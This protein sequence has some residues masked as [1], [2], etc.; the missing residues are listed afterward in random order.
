MEKF[1]PANN[2]EDRGAESVKL[3]NAFE[4][5]TPEQ[6]LR[7]LEQKEETS[8]FKKLADY[9]KELPGN[10]FRKNK[11]VKAAAA[12]SLMLKASTLFSGLA[13]A[14][15][16]KK[17]S[18][19]AGRGSAVA[20]NLDAINLEPPFD[21][22]QIV[23]EISLSYEAPHINRS[24]YQ[25][26][27]AEF[28][29]HFGLPFGMD[30]EEHKPAVFFKDMTWDEYDAAEKFYYKNFHSSESASEFFR[31]FQIDAGDYSSK[32]KMMILRFLGWKLAMNFDKDMLERGD[33]AFVSD[34]AMFEALKAG[35]PAGICGNQ[36]TFLAKAAK[37]LGVEAWL[38]SEDNH[39]VTGAIAENQG[40]KEIVFFNIIDNKNVSFIP[41]GTLNYKEA[42]GIMERSTK[43]IALFNTIVGNTE[44]QLFPVNSYA[45][46]NM[47]EA[48]GFKNKDEALSEKLVAGEIVRPRNIEI[49]FSPEKKKFEFNRDSI[50]LCFFDYR[51]SGNAYNSLEELNS[52]RGSLRLG[53]NHWGI[54]AETTFMHF[55][56]KDFYDNKFPRE[57]V[58]SRLAGD[59]ID[60][61]QL[62]KGEFGSLAASY[63]ATVEGGMNYLLHKDNFAQETFYQG[64]GGAGARVIYLTPGE[65]GKIFLE[66]KNFWHGQCNDF[67]RQDLV[68]KETS[69]QLALGGSREVREGKILN[70]EVSAA[71]MD[72]G[73]AYAIKGG[74]KRDNLKSEFGYKKIK[75]E[76]ERF[77][78]SSDEIEGSL[79][80]E[81]Q[82]ESE[83]PFGEINIFGT[84]GREKYKDAKAETIGNVGVVLRIFLWE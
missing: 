31:N 66:T 62:T 30:N 40:E 15:E 50:G 17:Y 34:D 7:Q 75:S 41:T 74:I 54:E 12:F 72:Y 58:V 44:E 51:D 83:R 11:N 10:F 6:A 77:K 39:I 1:N 71:K 82:G 43:E 36:G 9:F 4:A 16:A 70:F 61:H 57:A 27:K 35:K 52:A 3:K 22:R 37:N 46:E 81:L 20:R 59:Y 68:L 33:Y 49:K 79:G 18:P 32:Q 8:V 67:Q 14:Q 80:Y 47:K 69:R 23:D 45:E 2:P 55:S 56:V 29:E 60:S 21:W 28:T 84:I 76:Y 13:W 53:G 24:D 26:E 38:Q 63:G 19:A 5:E 73:S 48:A 42:L 65:S 78:P 25:P 64:E